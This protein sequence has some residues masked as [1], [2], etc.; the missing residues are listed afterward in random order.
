M[1]GTMLACNGVEL[2][3]ETFGDPAAPPVLLMMGNSCPGL[4]WP[5]AFCHAL[6]EVG[7][8][9]I[10]FDQRDT[11]YSTYFDFET[12]PYNLH[13]MAADVLALLDAL[14]LESAH[15]VGLSQGATLGYML[16]RSHPQRVRSLTTLMGSPDMSAKNDAFAGKDTSAAPLPP[17]TPEF[18]AGVIA[19][20]AAPPA[21]DAE[22]VAQLVGNFRLAAGPA[23]AFDEAFWHDLMT[24]M[25][26]QRNT[27][28]DGEVA[29]VANHG[30]H[31]RAQSATRPVTF[32]EL[33][34]I[35]VPTLVIHGTGDPI[36]PPAHAQAVVAAVPDARLL[37]VPTMGHA[38]DPAYFDVITRAILAHVQRVDGD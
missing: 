33:T 8:R 16:S 29:E 20:N 28:P 9:V 15:L 38:L 4:M 1:P 7:L 36:F 12:T 14:G 25:V 24:R 6:A 22:A 13:D 11:G 26:A 18:V 34:Q 35:T 37:L 19:L 2:W 31:S 32:E 5:D 30:N 3:C 21:N 10:R 17:P 23:S 27:R